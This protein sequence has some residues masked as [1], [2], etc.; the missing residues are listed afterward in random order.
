MDTSSLLEI[1]YSSPISFYSV[2]FSVLIIL[3]G[4]AATGLVADTSIDIDAIDVADGLKVL[5]AHFHIS[6]VPIVIFLFFYSMYGTLSLVFVRETFNNET[7]TMVLA[8]ANVYLCAKASGLTI[9]PFI[10]Y[11][12][13]EEPKISYIGQEA[14]VGSSTVTKKGGFVDCDIDDT[15]HQLHAF[16]ENDVVLKKGDKVVILRQDDEK[17]LVEKFDF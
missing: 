13:L 1:I 9:R 4:L 8:I 11:V 7:I 14:I 15:E 12:A 6:R 16:V 17:Y 2:P 10:K 3:V 5:L